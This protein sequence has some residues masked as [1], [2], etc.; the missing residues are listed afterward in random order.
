MNFNIYC[1]AKFGVKQY[2]VHKCRWLIDTNLE[3]AR[4][5]LKSEAGINDRQHIINTAQQHKWR[6]WRIL[7]SHSL[8]LKILYIQILDPFHLTNIRDYAI[9]LRIIARIFSLCFLFWTYVHN[10]H[11]LI[12][13]HNIPFSCF[14]RSVCF[15]RQYVKCRPYGS[16]I[17]CLLLTTSAL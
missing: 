5:P 9:W 3:S 8:S 2:C 7:I 4:V 6:N 14:W 17:L 1:G 13:I 15:S 11:H 10:N 16:D 12:I